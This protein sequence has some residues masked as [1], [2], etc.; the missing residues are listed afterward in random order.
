M[1]QENGGQIKM[2]LPIWA[3]KEELSAYAAR[4][5]VVATDIIERMKRQL[6]E[7]AENYASRPVQDV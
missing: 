1:A 6:E 7:E 4:R 5:N 3:L 2:D